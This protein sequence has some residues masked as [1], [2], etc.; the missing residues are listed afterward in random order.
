MKVNFLLSGWRYEHAFW[1]SLDSVVA[2]AEAE[3]SS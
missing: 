3:N 2:I 1:F